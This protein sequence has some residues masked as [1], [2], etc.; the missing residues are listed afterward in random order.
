MIRPTMLIAVLGVCATGLVSV[1]P[2]FAATAPPKPVSGCLNQALTD[3]FWTLK[4]TSATLGTL[5]GATT[6]AWGITFDFGNAQTKAAS[7][8]TLGVAA[9][10]LILK[11]GTTLDMT[12]DS[13]LHFQHALEFTT[14][15]PGGKKSGTY[16]YIPDDPATKA[17]TFLFP[18]NASNSIYNTPYGYPVKNPAFSVD[19]TCTK[20]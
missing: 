13:G 6:P 12:T 3:G 8:N 5:P 14:L 10:Q 7:P 4:V 17:A 1:A 19:L 18:V 16:W 20:S 11:D 2:T 9:P 15:Q